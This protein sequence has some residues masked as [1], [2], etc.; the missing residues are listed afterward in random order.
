MDKFIKDPE[1]VLDYSWDWSDYLEVGETILTFT[2]TPSTEELVV[3]SSSATDT[4]VT[5]WLSGGVDEQRTTVTCHIVTS[6]DREDD[7]SIYVQVLH[8]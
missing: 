5:A 2:V 4:T 6:Q 1:A 8:R 7:R 3:D